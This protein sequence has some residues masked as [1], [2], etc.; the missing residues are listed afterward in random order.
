M[1]GPHNVKEISDN[2]TTETAA[3]LAAGEV[4]LVFFMDFSTFFVFLMELV[5]N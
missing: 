2:F 3:G 5:P 1:T 4:F